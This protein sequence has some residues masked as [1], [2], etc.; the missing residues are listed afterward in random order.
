MHKCR[1]GMK[2]HDSG[3]KEIERGT[4]EKRDE[5]KWELD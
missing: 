1:L 2:D 4:L 5:K 3:G